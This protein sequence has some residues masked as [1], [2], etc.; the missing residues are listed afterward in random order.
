LARSSLWWRRDK[1]E[2]DFDMT[3]FAAIALIAAVINLGIG[4]AVVIG[5]RGRS[6]DLRRDRRRNAN[7]L[8]ARRESDARAPS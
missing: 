2:K 3:F 7:R 6:F 1:R 8:L 5:E 4:A